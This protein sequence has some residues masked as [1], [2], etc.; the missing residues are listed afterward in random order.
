MRFGFY[1]FSFYS[2][3]IA[4]GRVTRKWSARTGRNWP[5]FG[6][7]ADPKWTL[8]NVTWKEE[9]VIKRYLWRHSVWAMTF[10]ALN[11]FASCIRNVNISLLVRLVLFFKV[12]VPSSVCTFFMHCYSFSFFVQIILSYTKSWL[13][14]VFCYFVITYSYH[15]SFEQFF[16]FNGEDLLLELLS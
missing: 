11:R 16:N 10:V 2:L 15:V 4:S 6:M 3:K 13:Y 9:N 7:I 8:S 14:H 12:S 1:F 5:Q